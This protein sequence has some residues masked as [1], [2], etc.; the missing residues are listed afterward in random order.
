MKCKQCGDQILG[1]AR[2]CS[3]CGAQSGSETTDSGEATLSIS[4]VESAEEAATASLPPIAAIRVLRG[5]NAGSTFAVSVGSLEVGRHPAS[6][7]FLDDITVSRRHCVFECAPKDD[8]GK[9]EYLFSVK[10]S[11]SLN[12]TYVNRK[13]ISYSTLTNG[14]EI[15]I[16]RYVVGL[17]TKP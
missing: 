17:E 4:I 11:G 16:G 3:A 6:G 2:F 12:G 14:D 5:P 1:D 10:D 7:I 15:Q 9:S 8:S 13:L